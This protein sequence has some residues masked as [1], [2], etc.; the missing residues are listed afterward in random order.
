MRRI[1]SEGLMNLIIVSRTVLEVELA[2]YDMIDAK[3]KLKLVSYRFCRVCRLDGLTANVRCS[4][5]ISM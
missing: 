5:S 3:D 4:T 1:G 2:F